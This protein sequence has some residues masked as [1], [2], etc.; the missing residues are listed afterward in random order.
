M[1]AQAKLR[2]TDYA[3]LLL[4]WLLFPIPF[5]LASEHLVEA[6]T[7]V[8]ATLAVPVLL[9]GRV[10]LK[11]RSRN[12]PVVSIAAALVLY[13]VFLL[14]GVFAR[15]AGMWQQVIAVYKSVKPDFIQLAGILLLGIGEEVYWRGFLQD[16][17]IKDFLRLPWWASA[18]PYSLIHVVSGMP[19]LILAALPVGLVMGAVAEKCGVPASGIAHSLWLYLTLYVLPVPL[20]LRIPF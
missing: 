14:G 7:L 9:L 6:M 11:S 4:P 5:R 13:L 2:I 19:L 8:A 17:I 1:Y 3:M 16:Y 15:F 10:K 12:W 18:I 20:L